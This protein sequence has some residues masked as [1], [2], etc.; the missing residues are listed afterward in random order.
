[1]SRY[2][3]VQFLAHQTTE[4]S[5]KHLIEKKLSDK[6]MFIPIDDIMDNRDFKNVII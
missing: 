5:K 1:M 4:K 3:K 6:Q 2:A